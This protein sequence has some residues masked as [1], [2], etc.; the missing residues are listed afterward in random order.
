M[1]D[2]SRFCNIWKMP[3]FILQIYLFTFVLNF[4]WEITSY[5]GLLI[6]HV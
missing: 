2:H 4:E 5:L 1:K 3:Y 6:F